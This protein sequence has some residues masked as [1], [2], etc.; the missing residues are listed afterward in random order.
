M[1]PVSVSFRRHAQKTRD[2]SNI[3]STGKKDIKQLSNE[4]T[5]TTKIYSSSVN[6]AIETAEFLKL[7]TQTEYTVRVRNILR[8]H[9]YFAGRRIK[10]TKRDC[11]LT[12]FKDIANKIGIPDKLLI[13]IWLSGKFP[14]RIIPKPEIIADEI[15]RDRFRLP[16]R[17]K[18]T[19]K[20]ITFENVTHDIV[21]AALFQRLSGEKYHSQFKD[22]PKELE[23]L[24]IDLSKEGKAIMQFRGYKK[25]ITDRLKKI[26]N[27]Y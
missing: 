21:I 26:L 4:L 2:G 23:S 15:L 20:S 13:K 18:G 5:T 8:G 12:L 17:V 6:R 1:A 24:K 9:K 7:F 19:E 11:F 3:T 14:N 25:D 22:L 16:N 10:T 27:K